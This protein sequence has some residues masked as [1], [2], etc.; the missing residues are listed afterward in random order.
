MLCIH[1]IRIHF[2]ITKSYLFKHHCGRATSHEIWVFGMVDA[3]QK[4]A[5]GYMQIVQARN[6]ATLLP[7]IARTVQPGTT[8][9]S[10]KWRAYSR[11][12]HLPGVTS[13]GVVNHSLN[14][15]EPVTGVHTQAIESYWNRVKTNFKR[16][17]GVSGEQLPLHLDEFMWRERYGTSAGLALSNIIEHISEIYPV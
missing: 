13:H 4:P 6:A 11:V 8:I 1:F 10:D 7:I 16:M 17:K 3:S 14:F 2:L 9:W 12:G 15:V 5:L